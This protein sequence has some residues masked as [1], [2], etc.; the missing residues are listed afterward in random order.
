MT[1]PIAD[2]TPQEASLR[3]KHARE[4]YAADPEKQKAY[5]RKYRRTHLFIAVRIDTAAEVV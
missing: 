3:R 5:N 2:L 4:K 1:R